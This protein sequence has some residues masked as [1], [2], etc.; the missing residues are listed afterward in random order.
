MGSE[1]GFAGMQQVISTPQSAS[2]ATMGMLRNKNA[3][4]RSANKNTHRTEP[5]HIPHT[6]R[7][8]T[9]PQPGPPC[10]NKKGKNNQMK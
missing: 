10:T 3:K 2:A 8:Q 5:V 1:H 4:E 7:E 9:G 6:G